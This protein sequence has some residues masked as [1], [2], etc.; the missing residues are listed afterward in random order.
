MS[1][2]QQEIEAG[3]KYIS[4]K[5][6]IM[7]D[8]SENNLYWEEVRNKDGYNLTVVRDSKRKTYFIDTLDLQHVQ[9]RY[10]L[11]GLAESIIIYFGM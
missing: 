4:H 8:F 1:N 10:R 5:I 7:S 2:I 9:L 6:T 3:K 11:D